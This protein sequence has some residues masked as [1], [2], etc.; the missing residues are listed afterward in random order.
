MHIS[1]KAGIKLLQ[2]HCNFMVATLFNLS[3]T[4]NIVFQKL[5][6]RLKDLMLS[7]YKFVQLDKTLFVQN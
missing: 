5:F 3:I 4:C 6:H 2:K 1:I 7:T